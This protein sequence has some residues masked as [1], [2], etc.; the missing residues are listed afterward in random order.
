[1]KMEK[2]AFDLKAPSQTHANGRVAICLFT[3]D[4]EVL[5][6]LFHLPVTPL[7]PLSQE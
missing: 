4:A 1:M 2:V 3:W 7:F 6:L 5:P